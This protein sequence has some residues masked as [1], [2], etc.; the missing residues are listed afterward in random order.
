MVPGRAQVNPFI[1]NK[2]A[3]LTWRG[4]GALLICSRA[5]SPCPIY[6]PRMALERSKHWRVHGA[7]ETGVRAQRELEQEW[8]RATRACVS[9]FK[10]IEIWFP[11]AGEDGREL[12]EGEGWPPAGVGVVGMED[13][14]RQAAEAA[15]GS[16]APRGRA[17]GPEMQ[18]VNNRWSNSS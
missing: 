4:D 12:L 14:R 6:R 9:G 1:I 5:A 13:Q 7:G 17:G 2:A 15:A 3:Q 11:G 16:C 8:G 10:E 18:C